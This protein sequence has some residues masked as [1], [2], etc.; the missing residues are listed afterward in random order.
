MKFN[1]LKSENEYFKN[2]LSREIIEVCNSGNYIFGPKT[3]EFEKK[4]TSAVNFKDG[5]S[6]KNATDGLTMVFKKLLDWGYESIIIPNF[7]AYPTAVAARNVTD[8]IHYVD[9][10]DSLTINVDKIPFIKRSIVVAVN[11]FGNNAD[12]ARLKVFCS[13]HD[14]VLIEDCAQSTGSELG[15][16]V[17]DYSV[18]SFYPTKPLGSLGDGG[19][20]CANRPLDIFKTIRFYGQHQ[21][22]VI[23]NSGVN[24][25]MGEL[26]AG[27]LLAKLKG[28]RSLNDQRIRIAMRYKQIV[29]GI[30]IH[31]K[32]VYHQ[33]PI[34]FNERQ[35]IINLMEKRGIPYM[36]HYPCHASEQPGLNSKN[37]TPIGFRVNDKILSIL[38]H[39]F[40]SEDDI[41]RVEGFLHEVKDYEVN[42]G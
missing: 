19:M 3:E 25:R 41:C 23:L 6:V 37:K 7:T 15:Q 8:N 18:Y 30:K 9:V 33:F 39:P 34:L 10:D 21:D 26:Q 31:S 40:M 17:S 16:R 35:K 28:F 11:L 5:V 12:L 20:I 13:L 24:S 32:S 29:R 42:Q 14:S 27:I 36:I 2:S 22:G 4:F 38:I 1:D